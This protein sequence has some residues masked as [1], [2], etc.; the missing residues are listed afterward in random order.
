MKTWKVAANGIEGNM[1]RTR[2][3]VC[4]TAAKKL[5]EAVGKVSN[6]R[7]LVGL[8]GFVNEIIAVV[9]KRFDDGRFEP[10]RTI[11]AF[12]AK[13]VAASGESSNY[14]LVVTRRKLGGNGPIMANALARIGFDVSYV[15]NLGGRLWTRCFTSSLAAPRSSASPSRAKRTP[16]SSRTAS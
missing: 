3:E 8:D 11:A 16:W 9:N 7:A 12:G 13:I 15:G 2:E 1:N 10:I 6:T 4:E 5:I 14:E